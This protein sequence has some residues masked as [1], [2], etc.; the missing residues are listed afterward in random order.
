MKASQQFGR[1]PV[2]SVEDARKAMFEAGEAPKGRGKELGIL[3][4]EAL[5]NRGTGGNTPVTQPQVPSVV[6]V[7]AN[8]EIPPA[9]EIPEPLPAALPLSP[10]TPKV[11]KVENS[12]FTGE[13][14]QENGQ[15][16]AELVYKNGAGTERFVA[17]SHDDLM[18][19]LLE[20]KGNATLRVK[21]A[22]RREK[23]G[24][25][26]MDK[27]ILLPPGMTLEQ[28]QAQP[29][30]VKDSQ[31]G[32]I[33]TQQ[34]L[35]FIES[36]PEFYQHPQNSADLQ[37]YINNQGAPITLRN[38][39][40]AFDDLLE[41]GAL[42]ARPQR[43]EPTVSV[44]AV[45]PKIEDSTLAPANI[46]VAPAQNT[47]PEN[48]PVVRKRGTT[49]L[50]PGHSSSVEEPVTSSREPS[51]EE[52]RRLPMDQLKRI[53]DADRVARRGGRR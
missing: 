5:R 32:V 10:P 38:L 43:I 16:V 44:P 4:R 52:L 17:D 20:G 27:G 50:Q 39:E 51:D 2:G 40:I 41:S 35:A 23:L 11:R 8:V 1:V 45:A 37:K 34:A 25:P 3:D 48:A 30:E 31:Q 42:I 7:S 21:E 46:P 12:R 49:G 6:P 33:Q 47:L 15:W 29:D 14:K 9:I 18:V 13:I 36:H 28:Y 19:Q 24:R 22:V 26:Q 53:A